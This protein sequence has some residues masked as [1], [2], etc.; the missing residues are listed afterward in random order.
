MGRRQIA[1]GIERNLPLVLHSRDAW[2]DTMIILKELVPPEYLIHLHCYW[3]NEP[4]LE[5]FLAAFPR[6]VVGFSN[7]VFYPWANPV[8]IC[9]IV[10]LENIILETDA[11][12]IPQM[13]TM[14]SAP[15]DIP[16]ITQR[17]ADIRMIPYE[18]V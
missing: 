1:M 5:E 16:A 10:P 18:S 15:G 8:K 2:D 3:G 13:A 11:P 7:G 6:A 4:H 12:Y 9:K 17:V 14:I